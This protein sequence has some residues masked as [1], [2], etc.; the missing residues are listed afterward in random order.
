MELTKNKNLLDLC[1]KDR[2][3]IIRQKTA[4]LI[5][6]LILE[7]NFNS[8][9]E[10]GTAYGYSCSLWIQI[11][12]LKRIISLEKLADNH[13]I[14]KE[15]VSDKKIT[16]LLQDAFEYVPSE[17]FD[18]IFVD[19]PKSHQ[20]QLV[21]HYMPYLNKN[22]LIVIDNLYL[23]KIRNIDETK[24]NKNQNNLLKKLD[25]FI[26]WL[27]HLEGWEFKLIDI[28]DGVGL[29]RKIG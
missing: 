16:F 10:I 28:D 4:L 2:I 29:L 18:L 9:L 8:L 1:I 27:N 3:P 5:E 13:K 20:E 25:N 26:L 6:K 21:N 22:G 14:A 11:P 12:N 15:Y 7:N 23:N 24:R 19:G 17:K